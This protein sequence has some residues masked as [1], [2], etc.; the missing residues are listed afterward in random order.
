MKTPD[1]PGQA[2]ILRKLK[3]SNWDSR[4]VLHHE[5]PAGMSKRAMEN[6]HGHC[7]YDE[8]TDTL[9][10]YTFSGSD[11]T[12]NIR[13]APIVAQELQNFLDAAR[14][15]N[16][17]AR[18][19]VFENLLPPAHPSHDLSE[20]GTVFD[21][22]WNV[23][24]REIGLMSTAD[25]PWLGYTIDW[26]SNCLDWLKSRARYG[27]IIGH[28]ILNADCEVMGWTPAHTIDT[29]LLAHLVNPHFA[30]GFLGLGDLVRYYFPTTDWKNHIV[31]AKRYN[32]LDSA[33]TRRLFNKLK[34][35]AQELGCWKLY[36]EQDDLARITRLMHR[37]GIGLD[38]EAI[39]QFY[40]HYDEHLT[41]LKAQLPFNPNSPTQIRQWASQ[42]GI[43]LE[44]TT[45]ETISRLARKLPN[46]PELQ[47]LAEI[48]DAG[49][50]LKAWFPRGLERI[51]P[52]FNVTGTNVDRLSSKAPNVQNIPPEYRKFLK[53]RRGFKFYGWDASQIEN[54]M[55]A[56]VAGCET[57]LEDFRLSVDF[58]QRNTDRISAMLGRPITRNQGKTV[59]HATNYIE[60]PFNLARRLLGGVSKK[61]IEEASRLQRAYFAAYPEIYSWHQSLAR[62]V[63]R[64]EALHTNIW[65][66]P[67]FIY[68]MEA[69]DGAKRAAHFLGCS[70]SA[71]LVNRMAIRIYDELKLIPFDIV[72]DELAYELPEGCS[73]IKRISE[74]LS[75]TRDWPELKS[76]PFPFKLKEG[77]NYGFQD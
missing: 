23:A 56:L 42:H 51:Y 63:E 22:E 53:A 24:T 52:E 77:H 74:I 46:I 26:N 62:Q 25:E 19:E 68:A 15:P 40:L 67:G 70:P 45:F 73:E 47:I 75:D 65:G 33:Y 28:N 11:I 16:I 3:P 54:R 17:L 69:H 30:G 48:K 6:W 35:E 20:S 5:G 41:Q 18:P 64:G 27:P 29:M 10:G 66:R 61:Q 7:Y 1:T 49:K 36:S 60:K 72:H 55:V 32:A 57:M 4:I 34:E 71:R 50:S 12:K 31:D 44:D 21:L 14:E 39:E 37:Q 2:S 58:H 38:V 8:R 59:T 13:I 43:F 76:V 9:H